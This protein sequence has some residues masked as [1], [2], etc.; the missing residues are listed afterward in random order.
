MVCMKGQ[1]LMKSARHEA[2]LRLVSE[3]TIQTQDELIERLRELG[4]CVTQA[5]VSRDIRELKL[6]K[7]LTS[8]G[9]YRYVIPASAGAG[10]ITKINETLL[11]AITNIDYANNII[12]VTTF[13]G[14]AQAVA[15]G[16]DA[17]YTRLRRRG[18]HD[19]YSHA[20]R[21]G[22][23]RLLSRLPRAEAAHIVKTC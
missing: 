2:I 7:I 12:V 9:T 16:I 5:T 18:R 22:G 17:E 8:Q 14:M 1:A 3:Q 4:F 15:A 13:P 11:G 6:T 21:R 19:N 20:Q 23:Q 10:A